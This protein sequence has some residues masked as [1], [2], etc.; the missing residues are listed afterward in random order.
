M[1][2][3][4]YIAVLNL[5]ETMITQ[6]YANRKNNQILYIIAAGDN[7]DINTDIKINQAKKTRQ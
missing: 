5:L 4:R 3:N 1:T 7:N 6:Y 2:D